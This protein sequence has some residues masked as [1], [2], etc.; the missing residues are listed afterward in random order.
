MKR[1]KIIVVIIIIILFLAFIARQFIP[2]YSLTMMGNWGISLP[3]AAFCTEV[4]E[5]DSGSSFHGDGIR[6]HIYN[7]HSEDAISSMVEWSSE[8][9]ETLYCDSLS[10]AGKAWLDEIEVSEELHPDYENCVTW[11]DSQVDNSEIVIFWD[12]NEKKLY[13]IE[14]FI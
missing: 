10:D 7:Y 6:Y 13:V 11:Y 14:S 1:K 9:R 3:A 8:E 12:K 5:K 2:L 4:Y